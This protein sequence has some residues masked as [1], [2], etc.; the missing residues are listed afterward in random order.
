[1]QFVSTVR[2]FF[3]LSFGLLKGLT[4]CIV[5][6]YLINP[7][8]GGVGASQIKLFFF[9]KWAGRVNDTSNER[10]GSFQIWRWRKELAQ[11]D[12]SVGKHHC[13]SLSY[14]SPGSQFLVW[15][16]NTQSNKTDSM[17]VTN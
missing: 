10:I 8:G 15:I 7:L 13:T 6:L 5:L 4:V 2:Y 12:C 16:D 1:M 14:A 11:Q 17:N 9:V 3:K